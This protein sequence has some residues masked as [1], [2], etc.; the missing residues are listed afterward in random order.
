MIATPSSTAAVMKKALGFTLAMQDAAVDR[1]V[2][3]SAEKKARLQGEHDALAPLFGKVSDAA[4]ALDDYQLVESTK[5]QAR[6]VV[7][8]RVL[9]RGV[10][11]GKSRTRTDLKNSTMPGGAG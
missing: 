2:D 3:M 11:D 9:D 6:I 4:K 7:G 8:D 10:R 5:Y 1:D